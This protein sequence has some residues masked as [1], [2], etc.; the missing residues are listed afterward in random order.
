LV[1][2]GFRDKKPDERFTVILD[3][4]DT[5]HTAPEVAKL[6]RLSVNRVHELVRLGLLPCLFLGRQ[7]RFRGSA[8]RQ[9]IE[10][11]GKKLD[12]EG[13]WRRKKSA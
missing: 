12:G 9:F 2:V 7:R 8:L 4:D 1:F 13:G 5:I 11:G 6:L 10:A 3:N